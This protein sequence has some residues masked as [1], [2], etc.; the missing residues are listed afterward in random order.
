M[1]DGAIPVR[2]SRYRRRNSISAASKCEQKTGYF[3]KYFS[4]MSFTR[5]CRLAQPEVECAPCLQARPTQD[6]K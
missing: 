1:S 2:S 3:L 4:P 6:T 5:L